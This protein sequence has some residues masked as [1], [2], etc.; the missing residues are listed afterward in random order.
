MEDGVFDMVKEWLVEEGI[1]KKEIQD[2]NADWHYLVEFPISSNHVTDII[3]PKDKKVVLLVSGIVLSEKHQRAFNNLSEEEK[4]KLVHKWKMDLLFRNADFRF[5]PDS[6]SLKSVEFTIPI[7]EDEIGKGKLMN[8]L[9]EIFKCKLY[10][11]WS[12]QM[13]LKEVGEPSMYI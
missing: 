1:F 13:E 12:V 10:I 11:I 2:E 3:K 6:L 9:R 5:I 4:K 7:F 8:G